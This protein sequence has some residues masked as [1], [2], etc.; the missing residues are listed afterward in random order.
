MRK[1]EIKGRKKRYPTVFS[2]MGER[3]IW[4]QKVGCCFTKNEASGRMDVVV[5]RMD[6]NEFS[7]MSIFVA[8]INLY[9]F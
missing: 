2:T 8:F 1:N 6:T 9:V 3:Y 4:F 7:N 5:G